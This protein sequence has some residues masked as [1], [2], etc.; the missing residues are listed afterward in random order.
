[1]DL[2]PADH[3]AAAAS[4][5]PGGLSPTSVCRTPIGRPSLNLL[6][7]LFF[8]LLLLSGEVVLHG[9]MSGPHSM[10][11]TPGATDSRF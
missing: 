4:T 1:M 8:K 5:C 10:K 3:H 2:T 7:P 9:L 11:S 6:H